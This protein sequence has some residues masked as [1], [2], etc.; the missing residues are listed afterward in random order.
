M[1]VRPKKSFGLPDK[2][3]FRCSKA[4]ES[5][6]VRRLLGDLMSGGYQ[7]QEHLKKEE[8]E[9]L[10]AEFQKQS[11]G[12][13]F[14]DGAWHELKDFGHTA[15]QLGRSA[16]ALAADAYGVGAQTFG[17]DE[18]AKRAFRSANETRDRHEARAN[19]LMRQDEIWQ[20]QTDG[21]VVSKVGG[22]VAGTAVVTVATAGLGMAASAGIRAVPLAAQAAAGFGEATSALSAAAQA[23]GIAGKMTLATI[24]ASG[25]VANGVVGAVVHDGWK[26]T[27]KAVL[28]HLLGSNAGG[29]IAGATAGSA[30]GIGVA[31]ALGAVVPG[32]DTIVSKL[33]GE[34]VKVA[35]KTATALASKEV[36]RSLERGGMTA[37][38]RAAAE[39]KDIETKNTAAPR[40]AGTVAEAAV[41]AAVKAGLEKFPGR[42]RFIDSMNSA[43]RQKAGE[44]FGEHAVA[45]GKLALG[46]AADYAAGKAGKFAGEEAKAGVA[47]LGGASAPAAQDPAAGVAQT[48]PPSV[49]VVDFKS[50]LAQR[51][52]DSAGDHAMEAGRGPGGPK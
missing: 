12:K 30:A 26:G 31:A 4:C 37:A 18:A 48:A 9:K 24:K 6:A 34:G 21:D 44:R 29:K 45:G 40:V 20:A 35:E 16:K 3:C 15:E 51:R 50:K 25:K 52:Q 36:E 43:I 10:K 14:V 13:R 8:K 2:R 11:M 49:P 7:F 5:M 19:Q 23:E 41:G 39:A 28:G 33:A 32:G 42:D 17:A 47:R 27:D 46:A 1:S 38:Q 22:F